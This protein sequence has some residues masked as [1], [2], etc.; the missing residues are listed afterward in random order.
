MKRLHF[1]YSPT[2]I[3]KKDFPD[4]ALSLTCSFRG[5]VRVGRTSEAAAC[6]GSPSNDLDG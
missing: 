6:F 2:G 4:A 1:R 3:A 5:E